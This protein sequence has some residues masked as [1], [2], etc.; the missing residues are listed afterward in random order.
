MQDNK[1]KIG[2][3]TGVASI[4]SLMLLGSSFL[5]ITQGINLGGYL[6]FIALTLSYV[7]MMCQA[8]SFAE[9]SGMMPSEGAV[10]NYVTAGF[11]RFMG[12]TAT[13]A[14]Y[15]IVTAFAASAEVAVAGI[16]AR[17]NFPFLQFIPANL[18]WIIGSVSYTHLT[19]PT[20]V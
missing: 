10:Y 13:L 2:V 4:L 18:S 5:T 9:L 15:I 17:E 7:M 12:V 14:A 1:S 19:L 3:P 20:K 8:T 6:F 11:G 16:F